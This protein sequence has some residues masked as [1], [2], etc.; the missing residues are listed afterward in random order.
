M[1]EPARHPRSGGE[2]RAKRAGGVSGTRPAPRT[3]P[4]R[5]THGKWE[6]IDDASR[7]FGAFLERSRSPLASRCR[8]RP[9]ARAGLAARSRS[10]SW[11]A[12]APAAA[13]TSRRASWRS[14][15]RKSLGQPVVVENRPGAGGTTAAE[16]SRRSPKDGY[17]A[18]MMSNA[19]A[20]SAAMYKTLRYD[21]GQRFPDGVDGRHRGPRAGDGARLS[22]QDLKG[23]IALREGQSRQAE[24][25]QPRRRHD[26]AF[27]RR[28]DEAARRPR[29]DARALS[30]RRRPR[31]RALLSKR[32]AARV[33]AD[34]DRAGTGPVGHAQGHRRDVAAAHF[35]RCRT[36]RP[37]RKPACP[38]TT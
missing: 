22:G 3:L 16:R 34:P 35:R 32:R 33:R 12:S 21:S 17:T 14:R 36:F 20:I 28:T 38:A 1:A 19:H 31:S 25:R 37:S 24:F 5:G 13:P 11:S 27:R 8:R 15:C 18:L 10:A 7:M 29:H 9:L 2:S 6:G 26:A 23:V 4:R 30:H